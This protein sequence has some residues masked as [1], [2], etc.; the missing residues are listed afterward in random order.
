[1]SQWRST[2]TN[3][4][5]PSGGWGRADG[6][7]EGAGGVHEQPPKLSGNEIVNKYRIKIHPTSRATRSG[8][9][10]GGGKLE[11]GF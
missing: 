3:T 9:R 11:L 5:A 2:A 8:C 7:E 4:G 1:M 6:A 10:C